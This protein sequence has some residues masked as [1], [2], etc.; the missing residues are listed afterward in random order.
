MNARIIVAT[1]TRGGIGYQGKLPWP[2]LKEDFTVFKSKTMDHVVIM[3]R[4]TYESLPGPLK[5]REIFVM[6]NSFESNRVAVFNDIKEAIDEA[7]LDGR[8]AWICGGSRV[9]KEAL[10]YVDEIH[11]TAVGAAFDCDVF[12]PR[13]DL[14]HWVQH[15]Q[16]TYETEEGLPFQIAV[17][18][19][20]FTR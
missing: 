2:K 14:A 15:D 13:V 3:G 8:T 18:K 1:E 6:S 7:N 10:P 4:K 17:Y 9:Y 20:R 5:G 11:L 12:F 16:A 19:R